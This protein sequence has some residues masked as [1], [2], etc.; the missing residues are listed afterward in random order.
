[1]DTPL[2]PEGQLSPAQPDPLPSVPESNLQPECPPP[3]LSQ[4]ETEDQKANETPCAWLLRDEDLVRYIHEKKQLVTGHPDV[5]ANEWYSRKS[6]VQPSSV[7]L[8]IGDIFVPESGLW[9][10]MK[11]FIARRTASRRLEH[12]V[13]KSG[14]AAL[15]TTAEKLTLPNNVAGISFAPNHIAMSGLLM[16]NAGHIDPGYCGELHYTLINLGKD[17]FRLEVGKEVVTVLFFEMSAPCKADYTQRGGTPQLGSMQQR[18]NML[19]KDLVNLQQQ[20]SKVSKSA[21]TRAVLSA[22][23]VSALIAVVVT[24]LGTGM[25]LGGSLLLDRTSELRKAQE[26]I[27][28][29]KAEV[30]S[31]KDSKSKPSPQIPPSSQKPAKSSSDGT[32]KSS[33][34]KEAEELAGGK[35]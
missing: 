1:M 33:S 17:E 9:S 16:T 34:S 31:L 10:T 12:Y 7:D 15:V 26:D 22:A 3:V 8:H 13:L 18:A 20:I 28:K 27:I 29:L 30:E 4:R 32:E 25:T 24:I 2:L 5:A 19:S 21:A 35:K 14:Y 23:F 11:G 6:P